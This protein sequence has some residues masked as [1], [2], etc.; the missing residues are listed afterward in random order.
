MGK[1]RIPIPCV[2]GNQRDLVTVLRAIPGLDVQDVRALGK[3][4]DL[5]VGFQG[6]TWVV[7]VKAPGKRLRPDQ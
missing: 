7:E 5:V 2:D 1:V 6:E 3:G 4:F